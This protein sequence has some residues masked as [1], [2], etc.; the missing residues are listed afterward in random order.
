MR[1]GVG[2]IE[3]P[4]ACDLLQ[5]KP[6][7]GA[8][9]T[10]RDQQVPHWLS[11]ELLV[12]QGREKLRDWASRT[13][14]EEWETPLDPVDALVHRLH[15]VG[16]AFVA[17]IVVD[18]LATVPPPVHSYVLARAR[19]LGVGLG[20]AGFCGPP[21][22]RDGR[23][24]FLTVSG[25]DEAAVAYVAAHEIGHAW[26]M[27]EPDANASAPSA[28]AWQT[29]QYGGDVPADLLAIVA[30]ARQQDAQ[31]EKECDRLIRTWGYT[32]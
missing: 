12:N 25:A 6:I 15:C 11:A 16:D 19:F 1:F 7:A 29:L 18:V 24:W 28:M 20:F 32:R 31:D 30:R 21:P 17:A 5:L 26:L 23:P 13:P 10:Q 14:R 27:S 22:P 4:V 9:P 2:A 3:Y 8:N